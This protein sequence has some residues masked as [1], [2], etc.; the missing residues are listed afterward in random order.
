MQIICMT[1]DSD[2]Y[3]MDMKFKKKIPTSFLTIESDCPE[4]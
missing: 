1:T 3:H 4:N 2:G